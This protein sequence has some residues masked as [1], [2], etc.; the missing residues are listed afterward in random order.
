MILKGEKVY[1]IPYD[2]TSIGLLV[3]WHED[4]VFDD[5]MSD[6]RSP[7]SIIDIKNIYSRFL[8]PRGRLFIGAIKPIDELKDEEKQKLS[9]E[10]KKEME[11]LIPIG[12]IALA[13]IDWKNR[14]AELFGGIGFKEMRN[15]GYGI[16]AIKTILNWARKELG[17]HRIYAYVKA[18]NKIAINSLKTAGFKVECE[19]KDA[20]YQDGKFINKVLMA[21]VP[22]NKGGK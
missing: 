20:I 17:L 10:K 18:H 12:I 21:N 19:M 8:P 14:K 3:K 6:E 16:D 15:K 22:R 11:K 13:D 9:P 2:E 5:V 4:D 7:K 1:L